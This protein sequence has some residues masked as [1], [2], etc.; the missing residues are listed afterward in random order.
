MVE[1][2]RW[3]AYGV[4]SVALVAQNGDDLPSWEPGAHIDLN[5]GDVTRQYSLCGTPAD[6]KRYRVGV[7]L[8]E[9]SRGS[10]SYIHDELRVGELVEVGGPR[11]H[12]PV[13][14]GK[15]YLFIAGGIG[16]T[17]ILPMI[18]QVEQA[19]R[20]WRL[21]YGGRSLPTMAFRE[22]L[23][24]YGDRVTLVPEN[25]HGLIDLASLLHGMPRGLVYACGPEPMLAAIDEIAEGWPPG[26]LHFE[27]FT[28][29]RVEHGEDT[30]FEVVCQA[31]GVSVDVRAGESIVDALESV[32]I[33]IDTACREGICGTCETRVIEG[34]VDHRDS[35]LTE[36]DRASGKTMMTCVS[37]CTSPRLVLDL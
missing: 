22:R 19:G 2:I 28:P 13:E 29:K 26:R 15:G 7:L 21:V 31:S 1:E 24:Q 14:D 36:Q 32:D 25:E 30:A 9:S 5:V 3:E 18:E 6:R 16:I 33:W 37:R 12:F 11:N 8:S 4:V 23:G 10:S 27:R 17:P 20:P 34:D 35:I